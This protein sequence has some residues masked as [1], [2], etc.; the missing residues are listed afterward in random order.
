MGVV[1]MDA[2]YN[3]A[4]I[5]SIMDRFTGPVRRMSEALT[6]LEQRA[7]NARNTINLGNTMAASGALMLT[8]SNYVGQGLLNI[9]GPTRETQ[10]ALGELASVGI[11]DMEA[12]SKAAQGFSAKW[13]GTTEAQFLGA[14]YDIKS[15]ISTLSDA[16]VGEYTRMAALTGKATKATT[17][18]M[19]SLF[20]TGYGIFADMYSGM[21]DMEFGEMF[22]AGIAASVK[23]FKT[24]GS[25]MA[26][27]LESLGAA[28]ASALRPIEE[29]F[30]VLGMLQATMSGSEAGTKYG[31]FLESAVGAGDKLGLSFVDTNGQLLGMVEILG[32]LRGKYGE[33]LNAI[34]KQELQEAFGTDEAVALIDLMYGKLDLLRDNVD[35]LG[36][37]MRQG[38]AFTQG[39]ARAMNDDV[40]AAIEIFNQNIG[41]SKRIV[42]DELGGLLMAILPS[43]QAGVA[44]FQRF[45]EANPVLMR[46]ILLLLV[47]ATGVFAV[48]AAVI[49]LGSAAVLVWG[50]WSL[51]IAK[52]GQAIMWLIG[53]W[54]LLIDI[55][56][57][58]F[59]RIGPVITSLASRLVWLGMYASLKA[60]MGLQYL[61]RGA[62]I[63]GAAAL[64]LAFTTMPALIG[65]VWSFTAALLANPITWV[66]LGIMAL[67]AAL[68]L[69]WRN[70]DLVKAYVLN[71]VTGIITGIQAKFSE[72]RASGQALIEAFVSGIRAVINKPAEVVKA[73][74]QKLRNLLPFSD[75]KEGPLS[76]LTRS[77]MAL[78][79]TFAGGI[80]SRAP[81]LQ[82]VTAN[83]L[84]QAGFSGGGYTYNG[85][86]LRDI[87]REVTSERATYERDRRP[88]VIMMGGQE[89]PDNL[90]SIIDQAYRYLG[91]R[92]E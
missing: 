78:V 76:Q 3:L 57:V 44:N 29:Q 10:A 23:N 47:L 34:E 60:L 91:M 1:N 32:L 68:V 11:S 55:G 64:R 45:A 43:I 61:A 82:S 73:G 58:L 25:G 54:G 24:T 83:A 88:I 38:T 86:G 62:S 5:V 7:Q 50:Y 33:T 75:A 67:I 6:Q 72:W 19:T 63:F 31:A 48:S 13:S 77:G 4:V 20:A 79:E 74:L 80:R 36:M 8:A 66:I 21:E 42:G 53:K 81:M 51:G 89:Q 85:P 12:M 41:I 37:S 65:S 87:S 22:S 28:G 40:N 16:A 35:T 9:L 56:G 27:A 18:E 14:A 69:L 2:M 92:G 59:T 90:D 71:A 26:Q 17:A 39:M 15:G 52:V 49:A 46:V 84:G 70:W 30:S